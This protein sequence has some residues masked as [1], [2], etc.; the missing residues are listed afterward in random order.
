MSTFD[1]LSAYQPYGLAALRIIT[2][3]LFIEHGTMK[4]FGFPASQMSGSLP[5]L[6]LFAAL[7]EL[8]GGILILV[9][10]LTRPVA[11]LLA[12]EMAVAYFMAHAPSSFFP[13]VNQGDAAILFCFVFLYLVFS[14]PGAF[15][16]DNRKTA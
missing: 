11:F 16:V 4:L 14:G 9:G 15:A 10:L 8:V 5:P 3:L 13:A 7:L 12:G 1:R 2:A 6:M